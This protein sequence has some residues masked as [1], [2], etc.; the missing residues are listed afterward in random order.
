MTIT[1]RVGYIPLI[2]A[3]LLVTARNQGFAAAE[4]IDLVLVR[5]VTWANLRDRLAA[6]RLDAAHMLAPAAIA[7]TLGLGQFPVKMAAPICLNR[8]GNAITL[9]PALHEQLIRHCH[10]DAG[11]PAVSAAALRAVI[12]DRRETGLPELIFGTVYPFSMH[13]ILLHKW[14]SLAGIDPREDLQLTVLPPQFMVTGIQ[15]GLIDGFCAGAP[16]NALA[17]HGGSGVIVHAGIDIVADAP[18]KVLVWRAAEMEA[19]A[20]SVDALNR[21]IIKASQWCAAPANW[22]ILARDL[23]RPGILGA[24]AQVIEEVLSGRIPTGDGAFHQ[25]A[26]SFMRLDPCILRPRKDDADFIYKCMQ[27]TKLVDATQEGLQ[28]A[29]SIFREDV[30]DRAAGPGTTIAL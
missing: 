27:E 10:G 15:T 3:S 2:D 22:P 26:K 19:R 20:E 23:S 1:L 13:S 17:V 21:A 7:A 4:G 6:E 12:R 8:N 29:R 28:L 25:P 9:S 16:W 14:F 30:Y 24:P 5:D 18:E 11:D